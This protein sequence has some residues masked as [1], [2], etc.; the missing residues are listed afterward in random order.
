MAITIICS[1]CGRALAPAKA[2]KHI[3][4]CKGVA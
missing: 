2:G 4:K 1:G 3:A